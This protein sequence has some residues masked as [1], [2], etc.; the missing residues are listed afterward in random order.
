MDEYKVM[1][2]ARYGDPSTYAE[3]FRGLVRLG[4][5]GAVRNGPRRGSRR[6]SP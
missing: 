6:D 2:L 5:N 3:D 4:P 1:G